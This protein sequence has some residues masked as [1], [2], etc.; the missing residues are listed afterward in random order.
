MSENG[1][2]FE[3]IEKAFKAAAEVLSDAGIDYMLGG[4][5][6][7]WARGGPER[8]NDL[9]LMIRREDADRALAA[10]EAAGMLTERPPEGW[11]VKTWADEVLIDLIFDPTGVPVDD[12]A[13]ER[14]EA[15]TV[16]GVPVLAMALEDVLVSILLSMSEHRL[17]FT[18]PLE[19]VRAV[20]EQPDWGQ[21][22]ARTAD[23]P[24]ARAFITLLEELEVLPK[25]AATRSD[26]P[27]IRVATARS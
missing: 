10:F 13:F 8:C 6:A 27:R 16:W 25:A 14:A 11:L 12:Q 2:C 9:D 20:R 26:Q 4:S 19:L 22:R 21:I 3:Q 23:S 5:L 15:F 24:Y 1:G 17:D 7:A 18:G